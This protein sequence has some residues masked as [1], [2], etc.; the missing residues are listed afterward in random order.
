M[1]RGFVCDN[2]IEDRYYAAG[3]EPTKSGKMHTK[4]VCS[5]CYSDCKV[6]DDA[7]VDRKHKGRGGKEYLAICVACMTDGAHLV[8]SRG[9][10]T[11]K[12]QGAKTKRKRKSAQRPM[13][14]GKRSKEN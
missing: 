4:Y 3:H 13:V 5:H 14:R 10:K 8:W 11:N 1:S 9:K 12:L 7:C 2:P 6:A